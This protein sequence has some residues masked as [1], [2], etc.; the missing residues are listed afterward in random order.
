MDKDK[1]KVWFDEEEDIL[2]VSFKEGVVVDS[3]EIEKDIRVEYG[4]EGEIMGVE[5][6][7]L[8]KMVAKSLTTRLKEAV[9]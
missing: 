9:V 7:N 5:I 3:E 6:H 2:Y 4:K 8:T 1:I